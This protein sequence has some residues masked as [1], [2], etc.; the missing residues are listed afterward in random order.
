MP[1][2]ADDVA[3]THAMVLPDAYIRECDLGGLW[4]M[5]GG[6]GASDPIFAQSS[7]HP[8]NTDSQFFTIA[9][10]SNHL[11]LPGESYAGIY[12]PNL[13]R[14]VVEGNAE[15]QLPYINLV[16]YL[17]GNG[18]FSWCNV[19]VQVVSFMGQPWASPWCGWVR[20]LNAAKLA[21]RASMQTS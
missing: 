16:G 11:R 2:L 21:V 19:L 18:R 20:Q 9:R 6:A 17:V 3:V 13:A 4:E 8:V 15:G 5:Q 10:P 7:A 14:A 1:W 12:V